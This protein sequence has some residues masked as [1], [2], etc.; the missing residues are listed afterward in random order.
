[1]FSFIALLLVG[2]GDRIE[3]GRAKASPAVTPILAANACSGTQLNARVVNSASN[4]QAIV[5]DFVS[6]IFDPSS[7]LGT[8]SGAANANTGIDF[9]LD[10][11]FDENH[12][13]VRQTSVFSMTIK[14]SYSVNG[15]PTGDKYDPI[16]IVHTSDSQLSGGF[17]PNQGT[18]KITF[19]DSEGTISIE[20]QIVEG[21]LRG[22]VAFQNSVSWDGSSPKSGQLGSFVANS[23]NFQ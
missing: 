9:K 22:T 1:M 2:C 5:E 15:S 19:S 10:L 14:D 8:V 13:I 20:G 21:S 11:K 16:K 12:Q 3:Y 23:C 7:Y 17:D 4:F 6:A 18:L